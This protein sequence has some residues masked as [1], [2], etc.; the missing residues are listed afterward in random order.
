MNK[1]FAERIAGALR[2]T[3]GTGQVQI[4]QPSMAGEDFS[5]YGRAEPE[6]PSVL[7]WLGAVKQSTL[8]AS[9]KPGGPPLPALHSSGFAPDPDPTLTA[10]V[11]AMVA[12]ALEVL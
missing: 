8:A 2:R 5:R 9:L 7:F 10:G 6:V 12:A 4:V 1:P 3:M 11:K